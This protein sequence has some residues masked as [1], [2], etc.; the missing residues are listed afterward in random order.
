MIVTYSWI[1]FVLAQFSNKS[2]NWLS[3]LQTPSC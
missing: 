2:M 3:K 1:R